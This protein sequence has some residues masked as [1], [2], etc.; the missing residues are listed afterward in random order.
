MCCVVVH[1]LTGF[2]PTCRCLVTP[3][4]AR[5]S[6]GHSPSSSSCAPATASPMPTWTSSGHRWRSLASSTPS[7]RST[8]CVLVLPAGLP[9]LVVCL[10]VFGH[11]L[12]TRRCHAQ[13][14]MN[15]TSYMKPDTLAHLTAKLKD[16]P[17]AAVLESTI[18]LMHR[19]G[20]RVAAGI[21]SA[22]AVLAMLWDIVHKPEVYDSACDDCFAVCALQGPTTQRAHTPPCPLP[23]IAHTRRCLADAGRVQ[24]GGL[25]APP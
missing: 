5:S 25:A 17:P 4:T 23:T 10:F 16:M 21:E 14:L 11:T 19:I 18:D 22:R 24:A 1:R 6:R 2:A 7:L 12:I 15:C 9:G 3:I 20:Y 13:V 8:R